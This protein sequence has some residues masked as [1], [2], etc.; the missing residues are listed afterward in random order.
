MKII[1]LVYFAT[2]LITLQSCSS[3][4]ESPVE[5]QNPCGNVSSFTV[6]SFEEEQLCNIIK[7]VAK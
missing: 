5:A 6:L 4:K 7:I 2:I 3:S 1:K